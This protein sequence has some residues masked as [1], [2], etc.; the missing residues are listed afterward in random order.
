MRIVQLFIYIVFI[1]SISKTQAKPFDVIDCKPTQGT[2]TS[3][4]L[5]ASEL[6][7]FSYL[8]KETIRT[9][10]GPKTHEFEQTPTVGLKTQDGWLVGSNRGEFGGELVFINNAGSRKILFKDNIKSIHKIN[11]SI[12]VITGLSHLTHN[13]GRIYT[14]TIES[15]QPTSELTF[16]LD[17][18]PKRSF[19]TNNGE[20]IIESD[21]GASILRRDG[22]LARGACDGEQYQKFNPY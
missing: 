8:V 20:L 2:I 11:Q 1:A 18:S 6:P 16:A 15:S 7:N 13:V 4:N 10:E 9:F 3:E 14:I 5:P 17:G 19:V 12:I 21:F 22:S